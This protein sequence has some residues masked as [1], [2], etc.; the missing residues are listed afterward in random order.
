MPLSCEYAMDHELLTVDNEVFFERPKRESW[1]KSFSLM[2][3][4]DIPSRDRKARCM[5]QE[6]MSFAQESLVNRAPSGPRNARM[7]LWLMF[8]SS[9]VTFG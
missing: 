8:S 7:L 3:T 5:K 6:E 4:D 9:R 1:T 2:K